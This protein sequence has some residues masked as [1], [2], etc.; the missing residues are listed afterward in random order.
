MIVDDELRSIWCNRPAQ[1]LLDQRRDIEVRD[2]ILATTL[3]GNQPALTAFIADCGGSIASFCLACEDGDGHILFRAQEIGNAY[4]RR[5][6]G[7]YF[8]RSGSG[9]KVRYADL[10]KVF[11]LTQAEHRVLLRLLEGETADEVAANF[12]VSVETT[13][14]HIRQIYS[15]IGVTSREGLFSRL[16]P[17]RV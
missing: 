16:R 12:R 1:L 5:Y 8:Y 15:K 4:F 17:Y 2:G 9:F 13:R 11:N 14:S 7:I 3:A 6:F 10:D